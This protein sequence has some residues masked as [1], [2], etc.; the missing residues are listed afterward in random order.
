MCGSEDAVESGGVSAPRRQEGCEAPAPGRA[1][2]DPRGATGRIGLAELVLDAPAGSN[3][4]AVGGD[5]GPQDIAREALEPAAVGGVDRG[6]G[7][8]RES[9][10]DGGAPSCHHRRAGNASAW[11]R[12]QRQGKVVSVG[13]LFDPEEVRREVKKKAMNAF[14]AGAAICMM[15]TLPAAT[16]EDQVALD[17]MKARV[18]A[19][20]LPLVAKMDPVDWAFVRDTAIEGKTLAESARLYG[21]EERQARYRYEKAMGWLGEE[22]RKA[23]LGEG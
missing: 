7:V 15:A 16:P 1:V 2:G 5:D 20:V 10:D 4:H 19:V 13:G 8:E 23:G 11:L 18:Q 6:V 21:V 12:R 17:Q 14:M 3:R 9:I 22:L